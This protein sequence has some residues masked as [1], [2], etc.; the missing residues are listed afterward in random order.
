MAEATLLYLFGA[1]GV[2]KSALMAELTKNCERA[3][4]TSQLPHDVLLQGGRMIGAEIGKRR[5]AFSGTDALSMSIHPK[6][7]SWIGTHPYN[8]VLGEG[9]RLA[10][11]GFFAAAR[12]AGYTVYPFHL[13][14]SEDL[15]TERRS[16][17]GSTQNA[18]WM[19]GA[20][21]RA[22]NL[23]RKVRAPTLSTEF[24]A[25]EVARYVRRWVPALEVLK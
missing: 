7:V 6:A 25:E 14:L 11:E 23:A 16:A 13:A 3:S 2:G 10:T 18:A 5:S 1:P 15:L 17:R 21:T 8:L 9:A 4:A 22:E 12:A 24:P 20:T 19:K